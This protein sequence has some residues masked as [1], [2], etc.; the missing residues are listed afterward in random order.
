M[1]VNYKNKQKK[2]KKK[3]TTPGVLKGLANIHVVFLIRR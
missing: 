2:Q 1:N 3:T